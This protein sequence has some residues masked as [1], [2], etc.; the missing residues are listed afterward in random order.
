MEVRAADDARLDAVLPALAAALAVPVADVWSGTGRLPGDLPLS[1]GALAHGAVLGLGRP[2]GRDGGPA[3]SPLEL[4]VVG[5]PA[6]GSTVPLAAG[7]HVLGRGTGATLP[8]PDAGVS[9][10]HAL[11]EVGAGGIAVTDLGSTN[12][13]RLD[14]ADLGAAAR[15]WP[16]GAVLRLGGSSLAVSGPRHGPAGLRPAPAGRVLVQ[17]APQPVPV[18]PE[19][20]VRLPDA[21]VTGS[22]RRVAWVAVVLP[23]AAGVTM[24]WVLAAPV[25]LF[26]ALL[27]PVVAVATWLS[28][29]WS[30]SRSGRRAAAVHAEETRA[31]RERLAEAVR[32]DVRWARAAWPDLAALVTAARR[33]T[34]LLW[35]R[36]AADAETL[37]VRLGTGAGVTRVRRLEDGRRE[38]ETAADLPVTVDLRRT[39]GLAV[40][41]PRGP[42]LGV[43]AGVLAQLVTLSPPG[44]VDVAVLTTSRLLPDW[45]WTRWLP[46]LSPGAVHVRPDPAEAAAAADAA[47]LSWLGGL[48]AVEDRPR[49]GGPGAPARPRPA[50]WLV[51]VVDRPVDRAL[52]AALRGCRE[53]GVVVL[54]RADRADQLVDVDAVLQV[55]GETG[56]TGHLHVGGADRVRLVVDRL[57]PAVAGRL[58]RDLAPL[59]PARAAGGLPEAVRLL[60]LVGDGGAPV[61]PGWSRDRGSLRARL[62]AGPDGAVEVDLCRDGPHALV[63]GTTGSG[64]SELLRTLVAALALAHPPDRC[65]FLLVDYKGGAAFAEAVALPHTVGLVTDLDGAAT[66]RALRSLTAELARREAVLAAAGVADV[67]ALPT[68]VGLARLVIVVDEFAGL[69][70]TLPEFVSGLVGIAQRGRSLGVHLVLATQRPG[71]VVSP[72]I[73]ANCSLRLCL[74]TTGE[75]DSRDVLGGP[76][77]ATVPA[78]RPG[79]GWLRV[80]SERPVP[81]QAARVA[82]A[83]P[84][85]ATGPTVRRWAWPVPPE[86]PGPEVSPAGPSDL[87]RVADATAAHAE[88]AGIPAP[89]RPWQPP[90]PG[91]IGA[92]ELDRAGRPPTE[93]LVGLVDHPDRQ[94]REPLV[95]DLARGGGW[96]AVGGP[97]SGRTTLLRTVLAEAVGRLPPGRLHVHVLDHGGGALAAEAA[98]LPHTGTAVGATDALRTVRLLARLTEHT[99]ARRA[100]GADP[101]PAVLLLVDGVESLVAQLD[102][103]VPGSGSADLLRLVRDGAAAG[104]TCVLTGDRAVPGGRLAGAVGTRLVLPLP[105][106]AD[107]AVAG[108]PVRAVPAERPPGRA[109][110][111]EQA[112]ECQL[113]LPRPLRPA[114][115]P[116]LGPAPLRIPALP[117]DPRLAAADAD[118]GPDALPVGPGGDEGAVLTVD[119]RRAGGLL[120]VGPPGSGRTT[121]LE[122]LAATLLRS[123]TA[124]ARLVAGRRA[125]RR[126]PAGVT[127]LAAD[128]TAAWRAWLAGLDGPGAVLLDGVGTLADCPVVASTTTAALADAGVVVLAAGTAGE[129]AA[130]F[131]GPVADL[132]RS[133]SGL[134]LCPGPGDADLLGTRLPRTPV[135]VRPGSGWLVTGGTAQ[136]VQVA[137]HRGPVPGAGA[138][139]AAAGDRAAA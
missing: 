46:H 124:V 66:A 80:G 26:F 133:R 95:L 130:A 50:R 122:G 132:R 6:A 113:A 98:P 112:R 52:R 60:D 32:A 4:H 19:T 18:R 91:R 116:V 54:G 2:A 139:W 127:A 93:L 103:A 56:D 108:I 88:A 61:V 65:S 115:G 105:D 62:G 5:G 118:G 87:A 126:G 70:E 7:R 123:G 14:D 129:L 57:S 9:R 137:R 34:G 27:S 28:E 82:L 107:Y 81:F 79:R 136:R 43:L 75:A 44:E 99:A 17:T 1:D 77:A 131:R 11:L 23:A 10:R 128:D 15:A 55:A 41:G 104:L 59:A 125:I 39:G 89:H 117:P 76:E 138:G 16:P 83:A 51:L 33:R 12:G 134:L 25:F 49:A 37:V 72:E 97:R 90:L 63:A 101:G 84:A 67:A 38:P 53:A 120:V 94:R 106:R 135:P 31:A 68:D 58:A 114:G 42:A 110:L 3:R 22:R 85:G 102:E 109:L 13:S 100:G 29:R 21:P 40:T 36:G 35:H 45:S 20:E 121:T 47:L 71:G 30:G 69:V 73:R 86:A 119:L 48:A 92:D 8:L 96:L 78:D 24:A 111:G 64:K 74:R